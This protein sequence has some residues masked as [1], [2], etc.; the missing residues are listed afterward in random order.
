MATDTIRLTRRELYDLVWAEPMRTL[1]ARYT[2]SDVGLAKACRRMK[3]PVPG[4]GYWRRK[5]TGHPVVR[6]R[7]PPLPADAG[8]GLREIVL[9][10][11]AEAVLA[12]AGPA[13][14]TAVVDA[15]GSVGRDAAGGGAT[16]G[17]AD[18]APAPATPAS[19]QA[20]YEAVPAH[21]IVVAATLDAAAPLHPLVRQT[22]AALR[23]APPG[24]RGLLRP[25]V[26]DGFVPWGR[27]EQMARYERARAA[28][29]PAALNVTVTP[30]AVD[31]ALRVLDALVKALEARGYPVCCDLRRGSPAYGYIE[32]QYG[33]DR[34]QRYVP[35]MTRVEVGEEDA[36]LV[37]REVVSRVE[38]APEP[39]PLPASTAR[40]RGASRGALAPAHAPAF[41]RPDER[42][43]LVGSGRFVLT[44][45]HTRGN[46]PSFWAWEEGRGKHRPLGSLDTALGDVVVAVVAAGDAFRSWRER[47]LA[48]EREA[49]ER[50]RREWEEQ[51]RRAAEGARGQRLE[52]EAAAYAKVA[53]IR[54]YAAAVRAAAAG[55]VGG[56]LDGALLDWLAFAEGYAD[57][58]DP[59]IGRVGR[60]TS[61]ASGT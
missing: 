1:A 15:G 20:A 46:H 52:Q 56:T 33:S 3:V 43:D 21:R 36:F 22:Q 41:A 57:R 61:G 23:G 18:A 37:L 5:A 32:A 14:G 24:D 53:Q 10:A 51:Q 26:R 13:G 6:E 7:L 55:S 42:Y 59:L 9:T 38:R 30:P 44:I 50:A 19:R 25:F 12:A 11:R 2:V 27:S 54:A 8:A 40:R 28:R 58:L 48:R 39:P 45:P 47:A 35:I 31:R 4:R 29:P 16:G 60:A 49:H 34:G 17:T